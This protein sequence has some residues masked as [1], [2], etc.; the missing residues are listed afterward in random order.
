MSQNL[1]T[2]TTS[3]QSLKIWK[4]ELRFDDLKFHIKNLFSSSNPITLYT[5]IKN[6][7]E[8]ISNFIN[9]LTF[10]IVNLFD[11]VDSKHSLIDLYMKANY[12]QVLLNAMSN[13]LVESRH[14]DIKLYFLASITFSNYNKL[15]AK[16]LYDCYVSNK[17]ID[18]S[19]QTNL[20]QSKS[21]IKQEDI[22]STFS[23]F[24]I[25]QMWVLD[26]NWK[27][28]LEEFLYLIF[29]RL[30]NSQRDEFL[31]IFDFEDF[32]ENFEWVYK[33]FRTI[34]KWY[35][36]QNWTFSK[37]NWIFNYLDNNLSIEIKNKIEDLIVS[38]SKNKNWFYNEMEIL[39][40]QIENEKDIVEMYIRTRIIDT[41]FI[42]FK[43][44]FYWNVVD[45][46][47]FD[48]LKWNSISWNL[49][50][51]NEKI[52]SID[53]VSKWLYFKNLI[54]ELQNNIWWTFLKPAIYSLIL[55]HLKLNTKS[56]EKMMFIMCFLLSKDY[57]E[58]KSIFTFLYE[59]KLLYWFSN[60][61]EQNKRFIN[62]MN[63]IKIAMSVIILFL[64]SMF[65]LFYAAPFVFYLCVFLLWILYFAEYLFDKSIDWIGWNFWIKTYLIFLSIIF[66][67]TWIINL[68]QS[69]ENSE[70]L[71]K[72]VN[73]I[74]NV[75]FWDILN[76]SQNW[77]LWT[78]FIEILE[79][80]KK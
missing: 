75:S 10:E 14:F 17:Q 25:D 26:K 65:F 74:N 33:I 1:P 29:I 12:H 18:L 42:D 7:K 30:N 6:F 23:K 69:L 39:I 45:N 60:Y 62:F 44:I 15:L 35:I 5:N 24:W 11:L 3:G 70:Q 64:V 57:S 48:R 72:K 71:V 58:Y 46:F 21:T 50:F 41:Y 4:A 8:E 52:I 76:H 2:E 67:F 79:W 78:Y 73:N 63:R 13:Y 9:S 31:D 40:C 43:N 55:E 66:W 59:I 47:I 28:W 27:L 49:D 80:E 38:Y 34:T 68:W 37:K 19:T 61:P 32:N 56:F 36:R 22:V 51:N 20:K 16:W 77:D 54:I 53:F